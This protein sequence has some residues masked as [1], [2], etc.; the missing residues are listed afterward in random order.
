MYHTVAILPRVEHRRTLFW[1]ISNRN[2][3]TE[4]AKVEF[5]SLATVSMDADVLV[6]HARMFFSTSHRTW[7]D[8]ITH[9][10]RHVEICDLFEISKRNM[11]NL[12]NAGGN[13]KYPTFDS[14][15]VCSSQRAL[16]FSFYM[17]TRIEMSS[18]K[19][20][21]KHESQIL[22]FQFCNLFL[23]RYNIVNKERTVS[24]FRS[25]IMPFWIERFKI[26][27][28]QGFFKKSFTTL[29]EYTNLYR[30]H[31]QRFFHRHRERSRSWDLDMLQ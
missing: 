17:V 1:M 31:T 22:P 18:I 6:E 24:C 21:L 2:K 4:S 30:G 27:S 13:N 25:D 3:W 15:A 16:L 10:H 8:Q 19:D 5:P 12:Q 29:K 26:W 9:T 7:M 23:F 14:W 20:Y 28:M 11:H